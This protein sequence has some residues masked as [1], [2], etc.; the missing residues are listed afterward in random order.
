MEKIGR[1]VI[2]I[3]GPAGS[4]KNAILE[5]LLEYR[6]CAR[7]VTATTRQPRPGEVDGR[8]YHFLSKQEFLDAIERHEVIEYNY[9][10]GLDTYYGTLRDELEVQI[11]QG[12]TVL[13]QLQIVGADYLKQH[14]DALTVFI[15][16]ESLDILEKRM[17]QRDHNLTD[18]EVSERLEIARQE[19]EE[20]A[21]QYDMIIE[22]PDGR[23][24]E[25]IDR[26]VEI[27]RKEGY[28][29]GNHV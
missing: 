10:V 5:G 28:N 13:A 25:T 1:Q 14:Y 2:V 11:A 26:V 7:L 4:G 24:R 12:K 3:A 22:N 19:M 23:L 29:L 6:N 20:D 9:R 18:A 17:R 16:P 21:P 15:M 27:V 8:D